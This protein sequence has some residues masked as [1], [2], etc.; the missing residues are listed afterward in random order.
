MV[1]PSPAPAF[2]VPQSE[3]L[4]Q[5]LVVLFDD[6]ALFGE[7]HQLLQLCTGRQ[8]GK[9]VLRGFCFP[10]R[11]F[12]K[13]PFL[14]MRLSLP[15]VPM[16]WSNPHCSKARTQFVLCPLTPVHHLPLLSRE[17]QRQLLY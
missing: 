1:E 10:L 16:R 15:V 7:G 3:F 14:R 13:Q 12:D 17:H 2:V 11:P 5:F 9:P 8:S 6:P 4:L